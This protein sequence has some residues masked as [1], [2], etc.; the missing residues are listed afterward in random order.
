M[1]MPLTVPEKDNAPLLSQAIFGLN[2]PG[3][4]DEA[5][6][7]RLVVS[8]LTYIDKDTARTCAKELFIAHGKNECLAQAFNSLFAKNDYRTAIREL[9]GTSMPTL[10]AI[11]AA[12]FKFSNRNGDDR[13]SVKQRLHDDWTSAEKMEAALCAL[14]AYYG[15]TALDAR[16][17][18]LYSVHPQFRTLVSETT[19]IKF[20][21]STRFE[22][23]LIEA[24][25]QLSFNG[26]SNLRVAMSLYDSDLVRTKNGSPPPPRSTSVKDTS[27]SIQDLS[28]RRYTI[29]SP[30][31]RII[32]L[33]RRLTRGFVDESSETGRYLMSSCFFYAESHELSKLGNTQVLRYR[34]S[35]DRLI[36]LLTDAHVKVSANILEATLAEDLGAS[37][38]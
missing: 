8:G 11:L 25:Y 2:P 23:R 21:L 12:L 13:R 27:Y 28:V 5:A 6:V 32:E 19:A 38:Q 33:L 9:Q 35:V 17:T 29:V 22:R 20:E 36:E 3:G 16:E 34:I 26:G 37:K 24:V 30:W 14:G 15:Y 10:A 31:G 7:F 4:L 1:N 18:K